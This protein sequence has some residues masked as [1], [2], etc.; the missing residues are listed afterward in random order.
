[1]TFLGR[2]FALYQALWPWTPKEIN[3]KYIPKPWRIFIQTD[4]SLLSLLRPHS[5]TNMFHRVRSLFSFSHSFHILSV[6][7][8][9]ILLGFPA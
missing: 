2:I 1:M 9:Y 7:A 4:F 6:N 5:L 3:Q 8:I